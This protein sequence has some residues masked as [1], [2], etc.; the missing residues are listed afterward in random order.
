VITDLYRRVQP[1]LRYELNDL[2]ELHEE[3]CPCGSAFRRIR[4]VHGRADSILHLPASAGGEVLLMPDYVRRA[5]NEASD[6]ILE[7]Q[8]VQWDPSNLEVRLRL[9]QGAD[10]SAIES[11]VRRNLDYW[12][13][14]AGGQFGTVRFPDVEPARDP[15]SHK[16][17]RV[18]RRS[19]P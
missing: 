7:Y 17:V 15:G 14:R 18:V 2:I 11:G 8:V 9:A 10:R 3:E 5:V 1:F 16:L 13:H 4:R 12:A 19:H 6:L